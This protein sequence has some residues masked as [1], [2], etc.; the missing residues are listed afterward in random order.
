MVITSQDYVL[1]VKQNIT[2]ITWA[3][4]TTKDKILLIDVR[5]PQEWADGYVD[6]AHCV[7][8]GVLEMKI[9]A[10]L[11][12]Q[13]IDTPETQ[14]IALY[15]RSGARSALATQSLMDMGYQNVCSIAGGYQ[16]YLKASQ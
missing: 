2:E 4:F 8:R 3:E 5:E 9:A 15:C 16:A 6:G 11:E 14:S 13:S 1:R 10:L 7:P 12:Q